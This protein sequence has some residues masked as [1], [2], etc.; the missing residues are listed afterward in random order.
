MKSVDPLGEAR[1]GVLVH[2]V[3]LCD[4][5]PAVMHLIDFEDDGYDMVLEAGM[6]LCVESYMGAEGGHEG[7]KLEDMILVTETGF[8]PLSGYPFEDHLM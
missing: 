8:E 2:G 4:E 1:Y 7:V 5:Y 6:T 3:G